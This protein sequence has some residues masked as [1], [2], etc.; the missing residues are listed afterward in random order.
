MGRANTVTPL[1]DNLAISDRD[2]A[3][4]T[5]LRTRRLLPA[6]VGLMIA[7]LASRSARADPLPAVGAR[8]SI[9]GGGL[10]A[11]GTTR[12][13]I[14]ELA[15]RLE[16]LWGSESIA[17]GPAIEYRTANFGTSELS[18]GVTAAFTNT[19]GGFLTTLN[20]GYAWR[21]NAGDGAIVG[22]TIGGGIVSTSRRWLATSTV[23]LSFRHAPTG[24][25]R[26]EVTAGISLGG[27]FLN[28]LMSLALGDHG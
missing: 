1:C 10:T 27:G 21:K 14:F 5:R 25:S 24:P 18:G 16:A 20:A 17:A 22:A 13:A 9:G 2:G 12:G 28:L 8:L 23:Y 7:F 6:S 26:D 11:P 3:V 4:A 19:V 15:P